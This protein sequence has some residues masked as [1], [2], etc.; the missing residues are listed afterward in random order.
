MYC[1]FLDDVMF[2]YNGLHRPEAD[3]AY[4]GTGGGVSLPSLT[5]SCS[6]LWLH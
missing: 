3:E 6:R 1:R 4:G 5:A 2:S